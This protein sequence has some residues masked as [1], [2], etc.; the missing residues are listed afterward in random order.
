MILVSRGDPKRVVSACAATILSSL[1]PP[2]GAVVVFRD[3][4]EQRELEARL[5][6]TQKMEA[7]GTLAGGIAHDFNNIL[8]AILGYT[9]VSVRSLDADN[10]VQSHLKEVRAAAIRAKELVQHILTFT[11]QHQ[12]E[13]QPVAIY[14]VV[15]EALSLLRMTLPATVNIELCLN[16]QA[17]TVLAQQD[18][19]LQVLMN[20]C[21]NAEHAMRKHGGT[22]RLGLDVL[23]VDS[24][25]E[26]L[27]A[28]TPGSYIQ[29]T[30][31]D[32]GPGIPSD[33]LPHIFEPYYTT[34]AA[35]EGSGL[36]LAIVH[37]I[38]ASHQGTITVDST[39]G[40]GAT[41][42][43]YLPRISDAAPEEPATLAPPEASPGT[44]ECILLIEDQEPVAL[45]TEMQLS[46]LGYRVVTHLT[47]A[48][49]LEA[50]RADPQQFDLV[51]TDQTMPAMTGEEIAHV[52]HS[53]RPDVPV[54]LV[55]GFSHLVDAAKAATLGIDAFLIKP[56]DVQEMA[57]TIQRV[58]AQ[59][60]A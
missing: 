55:T 47:S 24:Q 39:L 33:V 32:S 37:G 4:S 17:G 2:Q 57:D 8:T 21:A 28:L 22:L 56:W 58:L 31:E 7:L 43:V 23:E 59:R 30:V 41:F 16:P 18:N 34:K 48:S 36:G 42:T 27:S 49:A 29:L 44:G 25:S 15:Q 50:F 19:L 13:R 9:H 5:R 11:R 53:N 12:I 1:G 38:V 6:Q 46:E 45:A 51:L 54:I 10:P 52:I 3:I 20:L 35:G 14:S 40:V 60:R 26:F